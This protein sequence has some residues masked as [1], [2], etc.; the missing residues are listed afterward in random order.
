MK[1]TIRSDAPTTKVRNVD[2]PVA[3]SGF[4]TI[5]TNAVETIIRAGTPIGLLLSLTYA[6]QII[7]TTVATY[8]SDDMPIARIRNTD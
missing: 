7:V 2:T 5:L 4:S 8:K 6:N 1:A 3:R